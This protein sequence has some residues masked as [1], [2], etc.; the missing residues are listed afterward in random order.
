M[1]DLKLKGSLISLLLI[2]VL[3]VLASVSTAS[4]EAM[5]ETIPAESVFCARANHLEAALGQIDR[6]LMGASPMPMGASMMVR[7]S[8]A[9]A[10]GD[11]KLDGVDM[12][13]SFAVFALPGK[14]PASGIFIAGLIPLTDYDQ[15][16]SGKSNY[17]GPDS[18]DI[19]KITSQDMR[20][21]KKTMLLTQC[22]KF[23]LITGSDKYERLSQLS[24][25]ITGGQMKSMDKV[26]D[27]EQ[28]K[29]SET[30]PLWFY[31]NVQQTSE[32]YKPVLLEKMQQF[33]KMMESFPAQQVGPEP[34]KVVDMY[35]K[36]LKTLLNE[37][38]FISITAK[39]KPDVLTI[40]PKIAALAGTDMAE[41]FAGESQE[42]EN[43]FLGYLQDGAILNVAANPERQMLEKI[44][45]TWMDLM[46][47]MMGGEISTEQ[48]EKFDKLVQN[49]LDSIG[50]DMVMSWVM[51]KEPGSLFN[52]MWVY[53][54]KD[55]D[56]LDEVIEEAFSFWKNSGFVDMYK[57]SYG[58]E[59]T[60]T[61]KRA[62]DT[63]KGVP[64][65][66]AE[67]TMKPV[68]M[69]S[70]QA[71]IIQSMYGGG[72]VYRWAL[73]DNLYIGVTGGDV[74]AKIHKLIDV[75]KEGAPVQI[76]DE[77]KTALELI[78]GAKNKDFVVTFN[79]IRMIQIVCSVLPIPLPKIDA[80]TESNIVFA[81][82]ARA[83]TLSIDVA[84]PK[85]HIQEVSAMFQ[86]MMQQQ[87]RQMQQ[88]PNETH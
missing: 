30:A 80:P 76:Q 49:S 64:I 42:R 1:W 61:L 81:G 48:K 34:K 28:K 75:I 5:L 13:G 23:A 20:G 22:G 69:N 58:L 60:Y 66:A 84:L 29:L 79:V 54:V 47:S 19:L 50:R 72:I 83:G 16:I 24:K 11:P 43:K 63:Y 45:R 32:V 33:R 8:L 59:T 87:R 9:G 6:F 85:K 4:A 25:S 3:I 39:P 67:F 46:I 10:L 40:S 62:A 57:K 37:V 31:A 73:T 36:I 38:K 51:P 74:D 44:N 68:D 53:E 55:K 26:V 27:A 88:K 77:F 52:F 78:E 71:Q 70:P 14:D 17:E 7:M 65:D 18:N 56:K 86:K 12:N 15:L 21:T 82:D 41:M 35:S 2:T